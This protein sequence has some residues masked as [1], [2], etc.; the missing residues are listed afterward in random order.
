[1]S[2][3]R[4]SRTTPRHRKGFTL[5]IFALLM[6]AL[7]ALAALVIDLGIVRTTQRQ[8]QTATDS[9]ALEGMRF[10]QQVPENWLDNSDPIGRELISAIGAPPAAP[11]DPTD[12]AWQDWYDLASRYAASRNVSNTFDDDFNLATDARNFGAGP[13]LTFTGGTSISPEFNASQ[14]MSI[15]SSR[16]YDPVLSLNS[17][18]NDPAGDIVAGNA[19]KPELATIEENDYS[20]T[21]FTTGATIDGN[22]NGLLVRMRRTNETL[23]PAVGSTG[24]TIPY[25]FGRGSLIASDLKGRGIAVRSTSIAVSSYERLSFEPSPEELTVEVRAKSIGVRPTSAENPDRDIPGRLPLVIYADQWPI[26]MNPAAE[27]TINNGQL[28]RVGSGD[29]LGHVVSIDLLTGT[30]RAISIGEQ[31]PEVDESITTSLS[32]ILAQAA[33]LRT[34]GGSQ[35][36]YGFV[37]IVAR[38]EDSGPYIVIGF[39]AILFPDGQADAGQIHVVSGHVPWTNAMATIAPRTP[40]TSSLE[41]DDYW[42]LVLNRHHELLDPLLAPA[43]VR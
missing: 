6:F 4:N 15:P 14:T 29:V 13:R 28:V 3:H 25:L 12:P 22:R 8:M 16:V 26:P 24:G 33:L 17:A 10:R 20:R 42:N 34:E 32:T 31:V 43:L 18:S 38:L 1:M 19:I 5:V 23:D 37:P 2:H 40:I 21:D 39:G 27:Y 11:Q 30:G 36:P 35:V 41:I 9:A 7:L